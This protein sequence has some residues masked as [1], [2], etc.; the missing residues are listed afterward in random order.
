MNTTEAKFILQAYRPDGQDAAV[1]QFA[2]AL[3]QARQDP[4]LG[5]WLAREQAFD[6]AVAGKLRAVQPPAELRAAILAGARMSRSKSW[7]RQPRVLALAASVAVVLGLAATWSMRTPAGDGGQLALSAMAEMGSP[8]HHPIVVGGRGALRTL[9]ASATTR[10]ADGI[11]LGF[12]ELKAD[13][14]RSLRLGGHDVMEVCF[15]RGGN[16]FHLYVARGDDFP[17]K[18]EAGAPM[19][20]EQGRLASVTWRDRQHAYVLVTDS[21]AD[22]LRE[23]F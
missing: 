17:A 4:A 5:D 12:A 23:V 20:L 11:P 22:R 10:L 16:E 6:A 8:E 14:C 13:G 3:A 19:F 15:E 9:L 2:E 1:P 7:W 18:D 21:G